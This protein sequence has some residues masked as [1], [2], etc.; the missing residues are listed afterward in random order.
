MI[1]RGRSRLLDWK[2]KKP[3]PSTVDTRSKIFAAPTVDAVAFGD[4]QFV[5]LYLDPLTEAHAARLEQL[6]AASGGRPLVA[7]VLN[8]PEPLLPE[9]ARAE[10]AAS[11]ACVHAVVTGASEAW[12]GTVP[13]TRRCDERDADMARRATLMQHVA[14]RHALA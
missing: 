5:L 11:L 7:V 10:L 12:I 13:A 8:P 2:A 6:A 14:A 9:R 1:V 3:V 4:A